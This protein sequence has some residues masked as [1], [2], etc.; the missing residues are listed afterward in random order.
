M[1]G[2]QG[3]PRMIN[4]D[5]VVGSL[6]AAGV[7]AA[8]AYAF[9]RLLADVRN[10]GFDRAIAHQDLVGAGYTAEQADILIEGAVQAAQPPDAGS[11]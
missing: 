7:P 5:R 1:P 9:A 6:R 11:G 8:Q 2:R 4:T 10:P 3:P